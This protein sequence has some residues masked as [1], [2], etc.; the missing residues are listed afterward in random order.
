MLKELYDNI[1]A[2]VEESVDHESVATLI[3]MLRTMNL[4]VTDHLRRT[5]LHVACEQENFNLAS[6]LLQA[7]VNPNAKEICDTTALVVA[8]IKKNKQLCELLLHHQACATGPL[9]VTIPSP[10]EIASEMEQTEIIELL[11]SNNSDSENDDVASYDVTFKYGQYVDKHSPKH[12]HDHAINRQAPG[13]LT[14]VVGDQGTCKTNRGVMARTSA[15]KWVGIIPGDMHTNGHLCEACFKEQGPGGF[16]FIV[17]KIMKRPKL[18]ADAFKKNK[19][20]KGNLGR[21]RE[22]VADCARSYGLAAVMEFHESEFYPDANNLSANFRKNGNH[23]DVLYNTFMQWMTH[24]SNNVSF[25]YYSRMFLYYGPLLEMFDISTSHVLGKARE[26]C[27]VLQLPA[28][29]QL[30]FSNY[31]TESLIHAV[32]FLGK[33]PLAFRKL[34]QLN[35][36]VNLS[37]HNGKAIELD[38]YVEAEIV[39]PMKVYVSGKTRCL[40]YTR[41]LCNLFTRG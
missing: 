35:C 28:F 5:L 7:G 32:N 24:G 15:H 16:H 21:I 6:C 25:R 9:F 20:G 12:S 29:A 27:Y 10:L 41:Q 4:G 26:A 1:A 36:D 39:Q 23:N 19:F 33:W 34:V 11:N 3:E 38:A 31:Y 2:K 40:Q 8:V 37:G 30:N 18:I 13:L 17:N 14:G 22:A